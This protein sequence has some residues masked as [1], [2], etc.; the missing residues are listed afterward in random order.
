MGDLAG[1]LG[2]VAGVLFIGW[3]AGMA[4]LE[5]RDR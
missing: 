1:V 3:F 2:I 5:W 4:W